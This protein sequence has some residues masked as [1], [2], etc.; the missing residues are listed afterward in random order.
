MI[1]DAGT[2]SM[3]LETETVGGRVTIEYYPVYF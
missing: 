1:L 3:E 2:N